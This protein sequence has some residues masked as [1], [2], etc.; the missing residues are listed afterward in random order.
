ML[1]TKMFEVGV[2]STNCYVAFCGDT[3]E[4]V[5][6]DPGFSSQCESEKVLKFIKDNRL[7]VKFIV[8]THGH[9]DH[10]CGNATVKNK[11]NVPIC[12]YEDDAF[13]LGASGVEMARYFGFDCVSPSADVLLKDGGLVEFGNCALKVVHSAGHSGGSV[14]LVGEE[15]V[16][17]GDTL[18]AGS[19]GRTDF[20]GGSE[21]EMRASLR[22]M[23][24]LRD[25]LAVYPG[26]GPATMLGEEKRSNP[27]LLGL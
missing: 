13:M 16:F 6:I 1:M 15:G 5:V 2:L 21:V 18:F 9:P 19:I 14:I 27:F 25:S 20:P 23:M 8:D 24:R 3:L 17:S 12:I 10:T 22:K 7:K 26:H 11:F 4:A